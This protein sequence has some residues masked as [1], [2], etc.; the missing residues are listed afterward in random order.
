MFSNSC[1]TKIPNAQT[2]LASTR[3]TSQ[4]NKHEARPELPLRLERAPFRPAVVATTSCP[5]QFISTGM[6]GLTHGG[7]LLLNRP[8][9]GRTCHLY[10]YASPH[11]FLDGLHPRE[12]LSSVHLSITTRIRDRTPTLTASCLNTSSMDEFFM[13]TAVIPVEGNPDAPLPGAEAEFE[14]VNGDHVQT[15]EAAHALCVI[16]WYAAG[17]SLRVEPY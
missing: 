14:F 17:P 3:S 10:P 9:P 16:T 5:R 13:I 15:R 4:N 12:T 8:N 7:N 1:N 11:F 6:R 2:R